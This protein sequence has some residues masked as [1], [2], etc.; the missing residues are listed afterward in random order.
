MDLTV[1]MLGN[2]IWAL[3]FTIACLSLSGQVADLTFNTLD[4]VIQRTA[5]R[6]E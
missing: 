4:A 1:S 6:R 5:F 3:V 2:A